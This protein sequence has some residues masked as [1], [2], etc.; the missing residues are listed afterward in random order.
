MFTWDVFAV[1]KEGRSH[2]FHPQAVTRDDANFRAGI[3]ASTLP[4]FSESTAMIVDTTVVP[5]VLPEFVH[6]YMRV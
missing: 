2:H 6:S 5:D 3:M 1:D 4:Y